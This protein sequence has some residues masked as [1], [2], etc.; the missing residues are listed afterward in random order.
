MT[1]AGIVTV[2]GKP[3]A[4]KSTLLNRLVG[5]KLSIVSEKPQST[6]NRIVGIRTSNSVQL[7]L[8]DTPGLLNP[9]YALQQA[10]RATAIQALEEADAVLYLVDATAALA[11]D[12]SPLQEAAALDKPP[13]APV[14]LAL[15]KADLLA[16]PERDTVRARTPAAH[17][18]SAV[19]GEGVDDL[20]A[21][22]EPLLPQSPFL[23]PDDEISTQTV[24]FFVSELI[25]EA[26]L[27]QLEEEVPYS[28]ACEVQ[29]YRETGRPLYIRAV[30]YVERESQ[31]RILIGAGGRRIRAVGRAAR[32][33][34]EAFVDAKVFLDLW[35]KVLPNWRRDARTLQR[36]GYRPPQQPFA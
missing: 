26:A 19:T 20:L 10:M 14:V 15:N 24:R 11:A 18:I 7:I 12:V 30:V 1:R 5:T 17:L 35:V 25:R 23:Y 29:E 16:P 27:E 2:A 36:L 34:I 9:R 6:R 13:A 3:N 21:A 32:E 33:K 4:G 31:K 8:L 28:V 22:I